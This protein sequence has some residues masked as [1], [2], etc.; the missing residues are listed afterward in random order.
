VPLAVFVMVKIITV[1]FNDL[2]Q[3]FDDQELRQFIQ[4][5]KVAYLREYFFVKNGQPF[6]TFVVHYESEP[7]PMQ[8]INEPP[9]K[10]DE[11][12]KKFLQQGDLPLY[13]HLRDWRRG[14]AERE[15]VPP[16]IVF[17]NKELAMIA[18]KRP[19]SKNQLGDIDGIG[20]RKIEKYGEQILRMLEQFHDE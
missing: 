3:G 17:T 11:S 6:L 2:L 20:A 16:Y 4:G 1:P 19:R 13:S 18:H 8:G 7:S 9:K 14:Q 10:I 15:G 12:W 5:K